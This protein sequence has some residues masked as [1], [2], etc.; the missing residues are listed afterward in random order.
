MLELYGLPL[1]SSLSVLCVEVYGQI[2][3]INEHISDYSIKKRRSLLGEVSALYGNS[4]ASEMSHSLERIG[5]KSQ[6]ETPNPLGEN[7]GLF[8]F[9]RTSPLTEVPF[10]CCAGCE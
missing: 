6:Q 9:L 3:K 4:V 10:I 7:L 1:D 8:R 2:T 5:E